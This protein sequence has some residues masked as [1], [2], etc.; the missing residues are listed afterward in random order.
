MLKSMHD[1]VMIDEV[2][3]L[4]AEPLAHLHTE[5]CVIDATVGFAGHAKEFVKRNIYLH[6][7]DTDLYSLQVA[8]EVLKQACPSTKSSSFRG[9]RF[10][11][12]HSNFTKI[13]DI[14]KE[15]V[16]KN[17][18]GVLI[19]L[20][21]NSYQLTSEDRG[22]SFQ[23]PEAVLDMRMDMSSESP[24]AAD[25]LN[26]LDKHQLMNLFTE[27]LSYKDAKNITQNVVDRRKLIPFLKVSDFLSV[28]PKYQNNKLHYA[29]LPF[30]AL[31]IAVNNELESIK[32]ALPQAFRVLEAHG[33]LAVISFH[34]MEDV[35]VKTFMREK[36]K[37]NEALD[38]TPKPLVPSSQEIEHNSRAR[39]AKLR[40]IEKI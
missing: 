14:V 30:M 25:L 13:E 29:T 6:G 20:G 33:R 7:I 18:M 1:P 8:G 5:V 39:S 10:S 35:I 12:H 9:S 28:I 27:V 16:I 22:M 37:R 40:I 2:V 17:I 3:S 4:I 31:R 23:N 38:L 36:I 32:I 26:V 21:V 24:R 15:N 19:D 11:L 34:S